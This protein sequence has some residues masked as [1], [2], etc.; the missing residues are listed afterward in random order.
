MQKKSAIKSKFDSVWNHTQQHAYVQ[1]KSE[2]VIIFGRFNQLLCRC[3]SMQP[4]ASI[5]GPHNRAGFYW[6][7]SGMSAERWRYQRSLSRWWQ[8]RLRLGRATKKWKQFRNCGK[9][10][11]PIFEDATGSIVIANLI[12]E[13]CQVAKSHKRKQKVRKSRFVMAYLDWLRG[14]KYWNWAMVTGEGFSYY[15]PN[16]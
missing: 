15:S 3:S 5:R 12:T 1:L 6:S 10:R 8:Q 11:P 16:Y 9:H 13:C 4:K 14:R 2:T 7:K